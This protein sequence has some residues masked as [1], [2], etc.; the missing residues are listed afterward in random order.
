MIKLDQ[1]VVGKKQEE[2][3]GIA[4]VSPHLDTQNQD[5]LEGDLEEDID[6]FYI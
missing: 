2:G 4:W 5:Y 6:K 3:S 1:E